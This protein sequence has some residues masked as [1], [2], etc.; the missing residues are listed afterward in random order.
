VEGLSDCYRV[1]TYDA[2]GFGRSAMPVALYSAMQGRSAV[3]S[4]LAGNQ[5]PTS[6]TRW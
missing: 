4:P 1:I 3:S 6:Y 5:V 2:R